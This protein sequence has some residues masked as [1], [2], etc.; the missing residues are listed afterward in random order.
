MTRP[1][2]PARRHESVGI[3]GA[4][5]FGI[6]AA[7]ELTAIG[8]AVTLYEKRADILNGTTAR[9]CFRLHR[10]YHY[11]RDLHTA[12]QARDGYLSFSRVFREAIVQDAP[13][14]YAIAA[15]G[16]QTTAEG[17]HRHCE[18]LDIRARHVRLPILNPET[19][20]A[21]FEVDEAYYDVG[22]LRRLSWQRLGRA[23]VPVELSCTRTARS[24]EQ[25]HDVV[26][27]TA[28][29]A[30]N[31]V[32]LELACPTMEVQFEVCEVPIVHAPGLHRSSVVVMDGPFMSIAPYGDDLHLLYDVIHS[33]RSRTVGHASPEGHG[34]LGAWTAPLPTSTRFAPIVASAQRFVTPLADV[35]HVGSM[36]AERVVLA[37]VD[38]TDARPTV[39]RWVTPSVISVLSGKVSTSIDAA[40]SVAV[41][42]AKKFGL[43]GPKPADL[44]AD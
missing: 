9:N 26:V 20:V 32:L 33:V 18:Q 30:L 24:I 28:Y 15:T 22:L 6:C 40:R 14:R 11:P 42:I 23:H 7:L 37:D 36:F 2:A 41:A 16:S 39:V 43:P 8:V 13:H 19:V 34:H 1:A 3:V 44:P 27:I 4:G 38:Q 31:Q 29:G 17:F 35:R 10:G 25:A 5:I 12:R 21:C